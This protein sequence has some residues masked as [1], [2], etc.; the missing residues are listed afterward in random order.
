MGQFTDSPQSHAVTWNTN[1]HKG[2]SGLINHQ[3]VHKKEEFK[4][5][6][7]WWEAEISISMEKLLQLTRTNFNY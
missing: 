6:N 3:A 4:Y 2:A 1:R 5:I 7:M